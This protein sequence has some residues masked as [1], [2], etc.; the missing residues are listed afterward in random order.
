MARG[1]RGGPG[2]RGGRG[3]RRGQPVPAHRAR[4]RRRGGGPG[5]ARRLRG[6]RAPGRGHPG[7]THATL[8]SPDGALVGLVV[9]DGSGARVLTSGLGANGADEVYVLWGLA[10]GTPRPLG[11]FD[12]TQQTPAVSSVPST[13]AAVPFAG[14]AVSIEPGRTAPATPTRV[15]A[16]GQVGT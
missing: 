13:T 1:G 2:R 4:Q 11:T 8:A 6:R 12:V 7:V 3:P 5:R 15:V 14:F 9:D 10:D 16:S